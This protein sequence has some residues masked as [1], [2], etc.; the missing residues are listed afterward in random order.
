MVLFHL[1]IIF[2][3]SLIVE[4]F[5]RCDS[6]SR[7]DPWESVSNQFENLTNVQSDP[8]DLQDITDWKD[9]TNWQD[10]IDWQDSTDWQDPTDIQELI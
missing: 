2:H 4:D 6:I 3:V 8:K 7:I 10:P 5:F 9:P 1:F